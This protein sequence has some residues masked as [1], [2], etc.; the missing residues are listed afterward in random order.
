MKTYRVDYTAS[1]WVEAEDEADAIDLGMEHHFE[2]PDGDW[3]AVEIIEGGN[4][5]E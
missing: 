3:Q 2:L 4:V 1:Y 5:Q